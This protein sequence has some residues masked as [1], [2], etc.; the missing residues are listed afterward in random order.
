[1][2]RSSDKVVAQTKFDTRRI[3]LRSPSVGR[4]ASADGGASVQTYCLRSTNPTFRKSQPGDEHELLIEYI[5]EYDYDWN[6]SLYSK[7]VSD[8]GNKLSVPKKSWETSV[9]KSPKMPRSK[10]SQSG[11]ANVYEASM[12][13]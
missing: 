5:H 8:M 7:V 2:P 3:T 10:S 9:E 13:A 12:P 4:L 6:L 1:M 11:V